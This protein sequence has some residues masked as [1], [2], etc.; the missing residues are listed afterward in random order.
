MAS[1]G[2]LW[3]WHWGRLINPARGNQDLPASPHICI[4]VPADAE[5][6]QRLQLQR[7]PLE[8]APGLLA[9]RRLRPARGFLKP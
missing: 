6:G 1:P 3:Q 9:G 7:W 8:G 4:C 5:L 2:L